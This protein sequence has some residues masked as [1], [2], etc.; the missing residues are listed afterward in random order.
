MGSEYQ[1]QSRQGLLQGCHRRPWSPNES[2][3]LPWEGHRFSNSGVSPHTQMTAANWVQAQK[4]D[5][6]INQVVALM[7]SK[8]LETVKMSDEMSQELWQYLRQWEKLCLWEG[9]LYQWSI[10]A[11]WDHNELQL[12]VQ[13]KYRLDTMCRVHDDVG[14]LGLEWM[15]DILQ[16][17]FYWPNLED[18]ATQHIRIC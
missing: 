9:V 4:V 17:W 13:P 14:H 7:K 10:Q 11:R 8:K 5:H 12:V 2:L 16:D 18:E 3:C 15:L 6:T 1:G